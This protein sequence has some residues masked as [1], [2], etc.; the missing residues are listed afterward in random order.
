[1]G[2]RRT[3]KEETMNLKMLIAAVFVV[4][5]LLLGSAQAGCNQLGNYG[6]CYCH[7]TEGNIIESGTFYGTT[8]VD[9]TKCCCEYD[10]NFQAFYGV[11]KPP[12]RGTKKC[13]KKC[14]QFGSSWWEMNVILVY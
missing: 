9:G 5:A 2:R 6:C 8:C 10:Q 3:K 1:M 11:C 7:E 12:P 13:K 4:V 14:L